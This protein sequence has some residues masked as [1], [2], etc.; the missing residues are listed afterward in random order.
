MSM[1]NIEITNGIAVAGY[2]NPPMNY[3]TAAGM[4]ELKERIEE[5]RDPSI[6]VVILTGEGKRLLRNFL[7][8]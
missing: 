4:A 3:M 7:E 8:M 6:R 1:W 2:V 5:W